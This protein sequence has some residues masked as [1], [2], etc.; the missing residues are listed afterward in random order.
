MR[1]YSML[2]G[3]VC[4]AAVTIALTCCAFPQT[5]AQGHDYSKDAV[6]AERLV[7]TIAFQTDGTY[8]R[9]H[10]ARLRIQSEAGVQEYAILR[11]PYETTLQD[12]QVVDV[13]VSR[14][15]G[16]TVVSPLDSIQDASPQMYPGAADFGQIHEKHV[17]VK[18]LE[19]GC[20]LEYT[21]KWEVK[22][23]L[24]QGQFWLGFNFQKSGITL[25]E[26]LEISVPRDRDTKY[27]STTVQPTI[28]E[29]NGRRI[30][31]WK[32]SHLEHTPAEQTSGVA[33]YD[34]VRGWQPAP[35][36]LISS[37]KSWVE[38]G[39][40]Y[41]GL[42]HEKV[43]PSPEVKAKAEELTKGMTD[44]DAKL[45]A[46]Y[47]YV[48][49][50]YHY[51]GIA[52][53]IGRYEPHAASEVMVNR[54]GD[55]K[56][57]HTLLASLLSAVAI[58]SYP[59][60]I[61]TRTKIDPD[62]PMPS[63]FDHVI[64]V[65]PKGKSLVWMDTTLEVMPIGYLTGN[66][67]GKTALVIRPDKVEFETTPES[68]VPSG[69][70]NDVTATLDADG[71]LRARVEAKYRQND[72]EALYRTLFRRAPEPRWKE[73]A[74][75]NF[76]GGRLGG[77]ITSVQSSS[78]EKTDEAFSI[79]YEYNLKEFFDGD[80]RRFVIPLAPFGIPEMK[81][82]DM[83]KTEPIYLAEI[84]EYAYECR[85]EL[86]KGWSASQP[87]P[88][89]L[90]EDFA[91]F[92]SST[93]VKDNLI[94]SKRTLVVKSDKVTPNQFKNYRAFEKALSENHRRYV[95]LRGPGG[96]SSDHDPLAQARSA[97]FEMAKVW[98]DDEK[99]HYRECFDRSY[100]SGDSETKFNN[101]A[102]SCVIE[103]EHEHWA[104]LHPE[105]RGKKEDYGKF[106]Q[107]L[108]DHKSELMDTVE[109]FHATYDV[110]LRK[111]YG[112]PAPK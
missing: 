99:A 93:E 89:D 18:G 42:Q 16:S 67:R 80:K 105:V 63:Q 6:V 85:L 76:Y 11:L 3:M 43:V 40:W 10:K 41:E 87:P 12:I 57:K 26:E 78:P 81:D 46:I 44:D 4:R 108:K 92:H 32:T 111:A 84:G 53:G 112:L 65:V 25:D 23:P 59:A 5:T 7:N 28:R 74:Q 58:T 70:I 19:P 1:H 66:L 49:L 64:S 31:T 24:A 69:Y 94:I 27:K 29:E 104:N 101:T 50:H 72:N 14:S 22:K 54:Y 13:R 20:V 110:C 51:V 62:V 83:E 9:E 75:K 103:E 30:Y 17:P 79:I 45:R 35:D 38:V 39:K 106:D 33:K 102:F 60:I 71:T 52:L 98:T 82:A 77:T 47:D 88:L 2:K 21:V 95:F 8:V 109:H 61:S 91:E 100:K 36:V 96:M 48:S 107:C 86:P 34:T 90:K 56:D 73:I 15:D 55:C 37:F 68:T 97:S